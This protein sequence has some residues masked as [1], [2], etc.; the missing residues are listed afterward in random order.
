MYTVHVASVHTSELMVVTRG[1]C[2]LARANA[3]IFTFVLGLDVVILEPTALT[4][5][6][7]MAKRVAGIRIGIEKS[8]IWA[9]RI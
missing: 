5:L 8:N 7:D 1:N 9:N 6:R 2:Q 4:T 3:I